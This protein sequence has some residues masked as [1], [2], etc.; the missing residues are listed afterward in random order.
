MR[1]S[2]VRHD[3]IKILGALYVRLDLLGMPLGLGGDHLGGKERFLDVERF[4]LW[5]R[6][7]AFPWA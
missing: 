2:S 5:T 6:G 1:I 7:R 4:G 3:Q